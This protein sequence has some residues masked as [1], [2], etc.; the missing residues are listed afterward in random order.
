MKIALWDE[1]IL[2]YF[3]KG[4]EDLSMEVVAASRRQCRDLLVRGKVDIALVPTLTLLKERDLFDVLPAVALS[5]WSNP[6]TRLYTR[7]AF[8]EAIQSV[9]VNPEYAQEALLI[10]IVLEEH[11]GVEASFQPQ[12]DV[13][14]QS[15]AEN[16]VEAALVVSTS[17][18]K[19]DDVPFSLD[20]GQDWYELTH[21]PMVWGAFVMSQDNATDEAVKLL[22]NVARYV[23]KH[24]ADWS[25]EES[26]SEDLTAFFSKNIRY[27]LDDMAIASMT[28]IQDYLYY[29]NAIEEINEIVFY[30]VVHDEGEEETPLL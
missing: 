7:N 1:P 27:R 21:Y 10:K 28:S 30:E 13:S 9:A 19:V 15:V 24:T 6:F 16:K 29:N 2:H 18:E 14:L 11:Y 12:M 17:F 22:R 3:R 20:L 25:Q 26:L 5:S 4:F 8:G 23:E